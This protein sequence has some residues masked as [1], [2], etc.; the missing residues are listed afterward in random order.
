MQA[1]QTIMQGKDTERVKHDGLETCRE[2]SHVLA[3][4][5]SPQ[6]ADDYKEWLLQIGEDVARAANE[7]ANFLNKGG[8]Q[9]SGEEQRML[10][11]MASELGVM[12]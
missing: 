1:A 2:V 12:H 8:V 7:G 9:V 11:Q 10:T 5:S 6:E 4:K 3:M